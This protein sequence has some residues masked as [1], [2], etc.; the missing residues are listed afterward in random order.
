MKSENRY[1][2]KNKLKDTCF[3]TLKS[4][5]SDTIEKKLSE[6]KSIASK[7]LIER[8]NLVIQKADKDNTVVITYRSKYLEGIKSLLSDSSKFIVLKYL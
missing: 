1:F 5:S 3:S 2:L 6:A 8:K 4:S 7:Y